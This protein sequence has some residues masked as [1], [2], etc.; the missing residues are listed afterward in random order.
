MTIQPHSND[1]SATSD[2]EV[3]LTTIHDPLCADL[4]A[5]Q[6][7]EIRLIYPALTSNTA[8]IP[9]FM[10]LIRDGKGIACGG[11]RLVSEDDNSMAEIKR[12]YVVPEARGRSNGVAD[13]L[14]KHLESHALGQGWTT[15]RLTTAK[16]MVAA[17]RFYERHGYRLVPGYGE[18][19]KSFFSNCYEKVIA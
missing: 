7:D 13:L 6:R 11:L 19:T 18:Y 5:R 4:I 3:K 1:S 2:I 8:V 17:N 9:V 14:L 10:V 16:T 12:V 15:V